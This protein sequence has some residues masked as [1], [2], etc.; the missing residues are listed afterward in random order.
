M[1]GDSS[2]R[3]DAVPG[4]IRQWK[5]GAYSDRSGAA[6][7]LQPNSSCLRLF[8]SG[9]GPGCQLMWTGLNGTKPHLES[10]HASQ[11]AVFGAGLTNRRLRSISKK[12]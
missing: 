2:K 10:A 12:W 5:G 9:H 7:F 11:I 3:G 8:E 6:K 1:L 4:A